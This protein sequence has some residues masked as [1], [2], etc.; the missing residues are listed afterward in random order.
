MGLE[1]N[2]RSINDGYKAFKRTFDRYA[3]CSTYELDVED[4]LNGET[5]VDNVSH[6]TVGQHY[7]GC[8]HLRATFD[9]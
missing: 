4:V 8:M 2:Y 3:R 6:C 7:S 9:N 5:W 1:I